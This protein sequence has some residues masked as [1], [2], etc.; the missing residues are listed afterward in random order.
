[1][2]FNTFIFLKKQQYIELLC[3]YVKI[4]AWPEHPQDGQVEPQNFLRLLFEL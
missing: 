4:K 3:T 1:M 2:I